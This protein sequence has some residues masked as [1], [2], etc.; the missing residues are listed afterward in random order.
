MISSSILEI[1]EPHF[2]GVTS[3]PFFMPSPI[4]TNCTLSHERTLQ[5]DIP[6]ELTPLYSKYDSKTEFVFKQWTF[7][8]EEEIK[9][10]YENFI[11]KSQQ[12][13]VDIAISYAG[14]GH[15][16]VLSYDPTMKMVFVSLDGGAN[17]YDRS[18]NHRQRLSTVVDECNMQTFE[19]WL[20]S[21]N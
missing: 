13:I 19:D 2:C 4:S 11:Y 8:S 18:W 15:V 3:N 21:N 14:M 16:H 7:L 20:K 9:K 10:R 1:F 6:E 5:I 17:D 12:R